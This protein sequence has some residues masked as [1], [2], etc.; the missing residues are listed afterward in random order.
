[1]YKAIIIDDEP[2]GIETLCL[3]ISKYTNGVKVLATTTDPHTGINLIN[4]EKPDIVFLDISMPLI[5]GFELIDKVNYKNFKLVFTT[6]HEGY[7]L[8]AIKQKAF[9]YLLKPVSVDELK[10]CIN[11][12]ISERKIIVEQHFP[13]V[14]ELSVRDG[15]IFIRPQE[16]IRLEAA[17]SYTDFYLDNSVKYTASKNLKEYGEML[18]PSIFYRC[19]ASHIV[20]LKKVS[21]LVTS[22]GLFI[23][24]ADGSLPALSRKNKDE[25]VE[26]LKNPPHDIN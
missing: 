4:T 6:A 3:L 16:I 1:M 18:N 13:S 2:L 8:K 15:I 9:D 20:N 24:M 21:R 23:Q 14:I 17:G 19:H 11:N 12:L 5:N 7:A 22:D 26:K 10:A 25:F